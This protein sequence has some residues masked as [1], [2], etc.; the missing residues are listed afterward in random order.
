M[1]TEE[2]RNIA[3][4]MRKTILEMLHEA[5]SGHPGGSLSMVEI[6]TVLYFYK[7]RYNS[8]NP[9]WPD[10]DRVVLSKGHCTPGLYT[11]LAFAGFFPKD[12]LKIF[13]KIGSRLSGHAYISAPGVDA[14]TGSLGQGLS[15]GNGMALAAKL[16]KKDYKIY[17]V[18][19]DGELQEGNVWEAV[20][21]AAHYKL[22]NVVA[23][24]DRNQMQQTG[25]T[26]K[27]K[28]LGD[29]SAKFSSFGWEAQEIDGHSIEELIAALDNTDKKNGKPKVIIA[30]TAKGKGVS[31]MELNHKWHGMAPSKEELERALEE[32]E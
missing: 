27:I 21:S 32:L 28:A 19:G 16:D 23:I 3:K 22:D 31:F 12:E 2:M 25:F 13:R 7:L 6:L 15:V 26:E 14:T 11:A 17:I 8:K 9:K 1:R 18:L 30:N 4:E 5:K 20:M 10:R 29:L 24:I